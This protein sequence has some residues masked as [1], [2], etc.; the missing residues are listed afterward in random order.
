MTIIP[1]I[2]AKPWVRSDWMVSPSKLQPCLE[3]CQFVQ[4][5][6]KIKRAFPPQ[7]LQKY[8]YVTFVRTDGVLLDVRNR[9]EGCCA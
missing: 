5:L 4:V 7:N 8:P 3:L 2:E 6:L 1:C 9:K